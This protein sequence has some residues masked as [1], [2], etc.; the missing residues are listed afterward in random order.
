[1]VIGLVTSAQF[2]E[3]PFFLKLTSKYKITNHL[4]AIFMINISLNL[5]IYFF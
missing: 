5:R 1:M 4:T 3:I 2:L